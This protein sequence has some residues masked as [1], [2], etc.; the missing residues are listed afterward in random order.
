M[1]LRI[2]RRT[3]TGALEIYGTVR[4]AGEKTGFRVRCRAGSDDEATA[5]EEAVHVEREILR[6]HHLGERPQVRSFAEAYRSYLTH[7]PRSTR[8]VK[9]AFRLLRHF[10]EMPLDQINQETVDKACAALL[11]DGAAPATKLRNVVVPLRAVMVHAAKRGWCSPPLFDAPSVDR[12]RPDYLLPAQAAA[13]VAG[14]SPHLRPLLQFLLCTGCRMGEA[15]ALEWKNVD[16]TGARAILWEGETKGGTRRVID[17]MPA[18]VTA[19]RGIQHRTGRVFLT[20]RRK[21]YRTSEEGGGQIKTAWRSARAAAKLPPMP[22][23]VTRHTWATWWY[24]LTPD[25]FKLMA[26]GGWSSV[27]LVERYAKIM[28]AGHEDA[29]RQFWGLAAEPLERKSA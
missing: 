20:N 12:R 6:R 22:P 9:T 18:A 10:G 25:P 8:T 21:P 19:L 14:A 27:K 7:E 13:L 24:A 4:P 11:R 16:L 3:D 26:E 29:I 5:R 15:L 2:R 28:P 23:H 17:L 1:P